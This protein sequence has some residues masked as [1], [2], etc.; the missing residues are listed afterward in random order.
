MSALAVPGNNERDDGVVEEICGYLTEEP[1]RNYFLFAGAGSGKTRTLVE[2]LRRMTGVVEH[3]KGGRLARRLQIYGRSIRV[4]TYTKNAV[5]VIKGRLGDNDLVDVSTIHAFCWELISGFNDDIREALVAIKQAQLEKETAE[6]IGKPRGITAAKQRDLD[7]IKVDIEAFRLTDVFIYNPDRETHGAGALAHKHVLDATAWLLQHKSTLQ[8]ILKDRHPIILIDE[9]QD[10]MKGIL[11]ALMSLTEPR[12]LGLTLGLLGDHRQRI[13]TDGHSDLPSLVPVSWATPEL[14]MNHRSQRR[15]V[16]LINRIWE[17]EIDGRTQPANGVEQHPRTEKA[18]GLVRLFIG[19]TSLSPEEKV[20]SER[21][22]ADQMRQA[23]GSDA[24]SQGHYQL[25]ALEHKLVATRG[26]F[27]DAYSAMFL[28]DP[29]SAAPTGSGENKGPT[30]V[31][32]LLNE[33]AQLEACVGPDGAIDELKATEVLRC[34]G[35]L[36][37]MPEQ[38]AERA[39]RS[40]EMLQA[41]SAFATACQNPGATVEQVLT[42]ILVAHLFEVD[43]RLLDAFA[44]KSPAPPAPA[45]GE[46]ESKKDRIRRGWCA[47]FDTPWS[48]LQK[49]RS[50]LAG[51]SVLA[52]HQV[53][54]GSEFPHVLVVMDDKLAGGNQ[55]SYDKIFGGAQLSKSDWDNVGKGKETTIDRTLRLLYVTCSRAKDSLA[56]VLWSSAPSVALNRVTASDWFSEGEFLAIPWPI[57]KP[58]S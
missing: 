41:I 8:T 40:D 33:L 58:H 15:I 22:C 45:R 42:P 11:D 46:E 31:Q 49:Y 29:N 28:I 5:A 2:V 43:H 9:S 39:R 13:Y 51:N 44:D 35:R 12:S 27:L 18:G 36:G 53:V 6:A 34:F 10:T 26:A 48:Q 3:E 55:I 14:Q 1:P 56:L 47:L 37:N 57:T 50:Y 54:K 52:T 21:W 4:V 7:E 16:T 32:V 20:A 24:W 19:D 23:S 38:A 25:L 30:A 17:A